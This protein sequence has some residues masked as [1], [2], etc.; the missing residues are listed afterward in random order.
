MS[1]LLGTLLAGVTHILVQTSPAHA[2]PQQRV[3]SSGTADSTGALGARW[4]KVGFT[5]RANGTGIFTLSWTGGGD[6]R[7]QILR[8]NNSIIGGNTTANLNPKSFSTALSNGTGYFATI[9]STSGVGTY[10]LSVTE[11][12]P[13]TQ[14][15]S[16]PAGLHAV[17]VTQDSVQLAWTP[18]TDNIGIAAYNVIRDGLTVGTTLGTTYV[19]AG[20]AESTQ[21]TYEIVAVD[22]SSNASPPSNAAPVTTLSAEPDG[23]APTTPANLSVSSVDHQSVQLTWDAATDNTLVAGY[24]LYRDG[25]FLLSVPTTS[26]RDTGLTPVTT[27]QYAV[28]AYDAAGNESGQSNVVEVT[29]TAQPAGKPNVIVINTDDQRADTLQDLPKIRQWFAVGGTNFTNGYVSTP[30]C[31]PS[32]ATLMSGRYVHNNQQFGQ[33]T[34]GVDLDLTLQR[35]LKDAG[36]YTGHSG[37]FVHWLPLSQVAPHWDRWTYFKGGYDNVWM[38]MDNQTV[39]SQGYSTTIT[40]DRALGYLDDFESR[41]DSTPFYLSLAPIAPHSPSTPEPK[42]ATATVPP[43]T[44]TPAHGETDR[45]DKPS[46]VRNINVSY[47]SAN[48]TKISMTRT[49]LSV[50]DQVDR[51]MNRLQELGEMDNTLIFYTS[52]NGYFWGEHGLRSKF[53]P[54]SESVRVPFLMRWPGKIAAGAV[55]TRRVTHADIAP[56]IL[57]AAGITQEHVQF[58]G[59]DVLSGYARPLALTE[60]YYDTA[61]GNSIPTWAAIQNDQYLYV[62]YYSTTRDRTT[63]TFREYYDMT[64]DPYQLQNLLGDASTANDPDVAGLS[65][66]L[67]ALKDCAGASC[68]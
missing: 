17:N 60:Y 28:R 3:L 56:T 33:D 55:D 32:R 35:Y 7:F 61:N 16:A 41:S 27:Y 13:D 14:P 6:L 53:L 29:T 59:H 12:V 47:D 45:T 40:F 54:Y 23:E 44:R 24:K 63:P 46:Y 2:I 37:K 38:R 11:D 62:E 8:A 36:Y 67:S 10:S 65:A 25:A 50:D 5:A 1:V 20:L 52:D 15:P 48:S 18:S 31:C 43:L 58:D 26:I 39:Q 21:Y 34:Q 30:S 49:L 68:Q 42:Y 64:A 19:D 22:T 51:L 66:Q 4:R 9:W 57:A